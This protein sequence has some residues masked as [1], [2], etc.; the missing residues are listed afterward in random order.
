[1][2]QPEVK[3]LSKKLQEVAIQI[4][5]LINRSALAKIE[6][7]ELLI[8]NKKLIQHGDTKA[9]YDNIGMHERTAQ[10]YMEIASNKDVQKLKKE[11]KLDGLNMSRILELIGCRVNVRGVNND[12]APD[13]EYKPFGYGKFEYEK[14]RS[15]AS[16]K[17]EY[18]ILDKKVRELEFE[19]KHLKIL[20]A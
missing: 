16:F 5:G 8:E 19:I 17:I 7:G 6:I 18:K 14:C 1:M 20:T 2:K 10:R 15:T 13:S 4:K 12:K 9:F 3:E 11:G